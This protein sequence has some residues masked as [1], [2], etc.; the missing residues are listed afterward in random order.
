MKQQV[1]NKNISSEYVKPCRQHWHAQ[2][3]GWTKRRLTSICSISQMQDA[4]PN[5]QIMKITCPE[6][7]NPQWEMQGIKCFLPWGYLNCKHY[8]ERKS[9]CFPCKA[10]LGWKIEETRKWRRN[11]RFFN[12]DCTWLLQIQIVLRVQ[13]WMKISR[14]LRTKYGLKW[15]WLR[16]SPDL[17]H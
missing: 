11:Y 12:A 7:S 4:L 8:A 14:L 6:N 2:Y 3:S 17:S 9:G 1:K 5:L 16:I 10:S 15:S 13:I